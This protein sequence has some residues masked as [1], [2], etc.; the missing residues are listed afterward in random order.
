MINCTI[1]S[2]KITKVYKDVQS[3][4]LP[5]TSGQMQILPGHAESFIFLQEG[6]I[7]LQQL[8]KEDEIV[9]NSDGECHVK[10]NEVV[11]IL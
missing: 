8:N 4:T 1:T 2:P 6:S 9:Q 10:D 3:I 7:L 5:A 11:I